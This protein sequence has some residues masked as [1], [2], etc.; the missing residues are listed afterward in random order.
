MQGSADTNHDWMRNQSIL[1][2]WKQHAISLTIGEG[3]EIASFEELKLAVCVKKQPVT[4]ASDWGF[5]SI[6]KDAKYGIVLHKQSGSWAHQMHI[7]AV[8][9]IK[10]QW[11]VYVGN[12]WGEKQHPLVAEGFVLGGFVITAELFDVWVKEAECFARGSING[13]TYKPNF[14]FL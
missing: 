4:I 7:R 9:N 5:A 8:F 13:R 2:K 12:Q 6:G 14:S 10:G 3:T 1:D 11:F